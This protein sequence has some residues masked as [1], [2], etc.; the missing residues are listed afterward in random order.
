MVG[1]GICLGLGRRADEIEL[2][3]VAREADDGHRTKGSRRVDSIRAVY[4]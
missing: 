3:R 4:G 1:V 2:G